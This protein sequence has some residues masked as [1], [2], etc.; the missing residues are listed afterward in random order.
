MCSSACSAGQQQITHSQS[1]F[2]HA[3]AGGRSRRV[4]SVS[5]VPCKIR[6]TTL[7]LHPR[8]FLKTQNGEIFRQPDA[9]VTWSTSDAFTDVCIAQASVN[10]APGPLLSH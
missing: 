8:V 5:S 3:W 4:R 7:S 6:I 2:V 1:G 10:K 9:T